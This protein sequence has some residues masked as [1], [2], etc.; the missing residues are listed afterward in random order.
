MTVPHRTEIERNTD[1]VRCCTVSV[2]AVFSG[3]QETMQVGVDEDS[4]G[5]FL[6]TEDAFVTIELSLRRS[7]LYLRK[8]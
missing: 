1:S 6:S 5:L 3:W 4:F 2:R 7:T 8:A